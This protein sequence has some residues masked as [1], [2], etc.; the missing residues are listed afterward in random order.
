MTAKEERQRAVLVAGYNLFA[1]HSDDV[2]IDLLTDSC[3]GAMSRDQWAAIQHGDESYAGESMHGPLTLLATAAH[4]VMG[5]ASYRPRGG[6]NTCPSQ[7]QVLG[8]RRR[9]CAEVPRESHG[10]VKSRR[11]RP[12]PT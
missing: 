1:L 2:L 6:P 7:R 10:S 12:P 3:T 9:M 8:R 4:V 11:L 5:A